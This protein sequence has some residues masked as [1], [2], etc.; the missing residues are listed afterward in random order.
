MTQK[1]KRSDSQKVADSNYEAKRATA[2]RFGGRC[3]TE[4]KEQLQRL[5]KSEGCSS[6]KELIFKALNFFELNHNN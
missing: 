4:E 1:T 3:T 5:M 2:P 6:E